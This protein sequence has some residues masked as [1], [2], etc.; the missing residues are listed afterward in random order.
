MQ[1]FERKGLRMDKSL[2]N[3]WLQIDRDGDEMLINVSQISAFGLLDRDR[4]R[5][6]CGAATFEIS[7]EEKI[8][9]WDL[10][11]RARPDFDRI[12]TIPELQAADQE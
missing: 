1:V 6:Y 4:W 7:D 8:L 3:V 2:N 11:I 10:L 12:V 9:I 5:V